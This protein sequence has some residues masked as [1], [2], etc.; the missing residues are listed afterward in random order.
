MSGLGWHHLTRNDK[1]EIL[2]G[3]ENGSTCG[4][5]YHVELHPTNRCNIN[6]FFCATK[7]IRDADEMPL[8]TLARLIREMKQ[9]GTRSVG[10]NGGGEPLFHRETQRFLTMLNQ[11]RLPIA[12]LTTNGVLLT[13]EISHLLVRGRCD[14]VVISLNAA[15]DEHYSRMMGMPRQTY[16]KVLENVRAL[17][18]AR[19]RG[20]RKPRIVLHFPVW[21]ENYRTIPAMYARAVSLG[22]DRINFSGLS[23]LEPE[24]RMTPAETEEMMG[25]YEELVRVDEYRRIDV[26]FSMEQDLSVRVHEINARIGAERNRAPRWK[27]LTDLALRSDF[28]LREKWRHRQ[29]VRRR[30]R[31]TPRLLA[32]GVSCLM[33]WYALV[34]KGD[35]TVPVCCVI[36]Q[37]ELGNV[38]DRSLTEIWH[39]ASFHQVRDQVRR[40]VVEGK[41]WQHNPD[42]DTHISQFCAEGHGKGCFMRSFYYWTD[43]PF[44]RRLGSSISGMRTR[45]LRPVTA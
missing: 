42:T 18:E 19:R 5:P 26:I 11:A 15:D 40:I 17:V 7:K 29:R 24:Q 14:Q 10:L 12:N 30:R 44:V 36:Q 32:Q 25:L 27:Q 41:R 43:G 1:R 31:A 4:G 8:E 38:R 3:L 35:G 20:S 23:F 39:S 9:M 13:P 33:P 2:A 37:K 28:T 16:G 21:K 34:V 45:T 6:C 22:V